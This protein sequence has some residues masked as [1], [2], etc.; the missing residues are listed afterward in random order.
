MYLSAPG[1]C[2]SVT[3]IQIPKAH[4]LKS[5]SSD[6]QSIS[7]FA[8]PCRGPATHTDSLIRQTSPTFDPNQFGSLKILHA[9]RISIGQP[10]PLL[11]A[12]TLS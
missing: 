8:C 5:V 3:V 6:V 12:V 7:L 1:I 4:R 11:Q 10:M 9:P 2:T